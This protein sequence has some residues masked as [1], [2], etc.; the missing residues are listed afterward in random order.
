MSVRVANA[1]TSGKVIAIV[2]SINK[3]DQTA[4][5]RVLLNKNT[6]S[7]APGQLVEAEIAQA[8]TNKQSFSIPK[9]AIVQINQGKNV[10]QS[11][12]FVQTQNGFEA[13]PVKVFNDAGTQA[14][15]SGQFNGNE[16]IVTSGTAT[17]KAKLQG[18]GGD[19]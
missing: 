15:I 8:S 14:I 13:R 7:L 18:V 17:L 12:V 4:L 5:V 19:E 16:S 6:S 9:N 11:F 1:E 2:P 3:L 10:N